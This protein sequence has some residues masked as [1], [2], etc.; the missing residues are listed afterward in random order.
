MI[1]NIQFIQFGN[2]T[3]CVSAPFEQNNQWC[4]EMYNNIRKG[5]TDLP[6]G[7][8][9]FKNNIDSRHRIIMMF[10]TKEQAIRVFAAH[11]NR[12]LKEVRRYIKNSVDSNK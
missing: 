1:S 11:T 3:M 12:S 5:R 6:L 7:K 8:G 4:I 9:N 2:A 10:P